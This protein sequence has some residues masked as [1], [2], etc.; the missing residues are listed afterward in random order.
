MTRPWDLVLFGA[1]G[2]TGRQAAA[3]LHAHAPEG[4]TWAVAG[5]NEAKLKAVVDGLGPEVGVEVVDGADAAAVTRLASSA[6]VIAS[7]AGPFAR[8]SDLLAKACA[9]QGTHYCDITGESPW[10]ASLVARDHDAAKASGARIV[11]M[12]GFDSIP[13]DLGVWMMAKHLSEAHDE[14]TSEVITAFGG[15]AAGL[16]GGTLASAILMA[17]SGQRSKLA[18]PA[19]LMPADQRPE[20]RLASA[21]QSL[22]Q[23]DVLGQLGPF[24]MAP[25]NTQVVYRSVALARGASA[26][27]SRFASDFRYAEYLRHPSR[28]RAV[29]VTLGLAVADQLLQRGWGRG[30]LRRFGPAPGEGPSEAAMDAAN[31]TCRFVATGSGGATAYGRMFC[32]GDAGN[33]ATVLMLCEAALCMV[34]DRF[35]HADGGVLTPSVALGQGLMDRLRAA[36]MLWE[37]SDTPEVLSLRR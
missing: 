27:P 32:P 19:L 15:G 26:D 8:Y 30:L 36:G 13:S 9:E 37:A 22:L 35:A 24:V 20:G 28:G 29:M 25:I 10:V 34:Q 1:T 5:R 7:T 6:R 18:N 23:H 12:C 31:T 14:R 33:R 11:P 3:Y 17:E 21:P 16:N 4:V 2:F